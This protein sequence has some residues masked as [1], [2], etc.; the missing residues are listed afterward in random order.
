MLNNERAIGLDTT[1]RA[2]ERSAVGQSIGVRLI[3]TIDQRVVVALQ[4]LARSLGKLVVTRHNLAGER[5]QNLLTIEFVTRKQTHRG[6]VG[7]RRI[8]LHLIDIQANADNCA[9]EVRPT[10]VVLDQHTAD[11]A[12]ADVDV[13]GPLDLRLDFELGK[14]VD[15]PQRHSLREQ[16]LARGVQE[17]GFEHQAEHQVF[18]HAAA[19]TVATLTASG[20]LVLGGDDVAVGVT[21]VAGLVVGRGDLFETGDSH[22][23]KKS[24]SPQI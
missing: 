19:P 24:L 2:L 16:K 4:L 22:S 17:R 5:L 9:G 15:Q 12:V 14:G 23:L 6:G 3:T 21:W 11:L 13:V 7:K 8:E 20:G 18:A 1:D 10:Q